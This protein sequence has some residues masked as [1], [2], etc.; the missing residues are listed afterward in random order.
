MWRPGFAVLQSTRATVHGWRRSLCVWSWVHRG[1]REKPGLV[2]GLD[3]G[4]SCVGQALKISAHQRDDVLAYLAEREMVTDVYVPRLVRI[5]LAGERNSHP[6]LTF[7][8]DRNHPQYAP[9][10]T[11]TEAAH[12]VAHGRGRSGAN[13]E[14]LFQT[15]SHLEQ[16]GIDDHFLK[17]VSARITTITGK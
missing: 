12:T 9:N 7:V 16:M 13:P 15:V 10:L 3:R 5:R 11:T 17:D 8:A 4:G 6:A 14:Y 2:M 1:T